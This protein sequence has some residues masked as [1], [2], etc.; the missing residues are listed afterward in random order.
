MHV[1]LLNLPAT[2]QSAVCNHYGSPALINI[3]QTPLPTLPADGIFVRNH[4]TCV[5]S[6][7][8]RIRAA[9][10]P[11][12]FGVLGR[13][14]FGMRA[15]RQPIL[16]SCFSGVVQA[17][18][19]NVHDV[20]VGTR[21]CGMTGMALGCHAEFVVVQRGTAYAIVPDNVTHHQ[22]AGILFGGTT[23]LVFLRDVAKL[24]PGER[25][26]V[27]GASGAIGT[28][29]VQLARIMGADVTGVTSTAN[30]ELVRDLG[31]HHVVDY[32]AQDV[33]R[34]PERYNVVLDT[35]GNLTIADGRRLLAPGG[36]LA[37][38]VANLG[39]MLAASVL[40]GIHSAT[41]A[42]RA[43]D[44]SELLSR[45]A[46]GQLRTVIDSIVPLSAIASAHQRVDSGHKVGNLVVDVA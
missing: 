23:A 24:A 21:L 25:L 43:T 6:A 20:A 19:S 41:A 33:R 34:L 28:A 8:A 46:E 3:V 36:R 12:G 22:A 11:R 18:G 4:A 5:T 44:V 15:P 45:I 29:A 16:G 42:E 7:D 30:V 17:V 2:M 10:F 38:A 1:S 26:L 9:R 39:Q 40:P 32:T 31:A 13:F 27:I 35:V 37:L 14:A